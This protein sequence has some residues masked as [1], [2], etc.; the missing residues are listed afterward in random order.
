LDAL[1]GGGVEPTEPPPPP[2]HAVKAKTPTIA[3]PL[4]LNNRLV[5]ISLLPA[6][7]WK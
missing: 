4:L 6:S 5:N 2:P 1:G 7:R 3:Q